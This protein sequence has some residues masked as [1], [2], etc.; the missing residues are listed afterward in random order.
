MFTTNNTFCDWITVSQTYKNGC[1]VLNDGLVITVTN[2]GEI[3]RETHRTLQLKG[4]YST[5]VQIRSDGKRQ[6]FSGNPSKWNRLDNVYGLNLNLSKTVINE[7]MTSVRLPPFT[8]AAQFS[9]I[10]MATI[11]AA[12]SPAALTDYMFA[13]SRENLP[14]YT[15][16]RKFGTLYWGSKSKTKTLKIYDKSAELKKHLKKSFNRQY[17]N[18]LIEHLHNIGAFRIETCFRFRYLK[19][20]DIRNW[21][22]ATHDIL[23]K[24]FKKDLKLMAKPVQELNIDDLTGSELGTLMIYLAGIDPKT[25]LAKDTFY[26]HKRKLKKYGYD[27]SCTDVLARIETKPRLI[28]LT[29]PAP[30]DWYKRPKQWKQLHMVEK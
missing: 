22:Q 6:E 20:H 19:Y 1:P 15:V 10:D 28:T 24:H 29:A 17:L 8:A 9:R 14:Q 27:I 21:E 16:S 23:F 12:G 30:P 18:K 13:K 26:K 5:S 4:S 25:R 11:A 3:I 2:D 7:I